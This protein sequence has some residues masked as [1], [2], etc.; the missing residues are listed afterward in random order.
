[1]NLQTGYRLNTVM[2]PFFI[3]SSSRVSNFRNSAVSDCSEAP[4]TN[5]IDGCLKKCSQHFTKNRIDSM[6]SQQ[7]EQVGLK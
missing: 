6:F 2:L 5:F 7:S 3:S 1:M 4:V